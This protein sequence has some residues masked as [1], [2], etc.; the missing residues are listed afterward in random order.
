MYAAGCTVMAYHHVGLNPVPPALFYPK[1]LDSLRLDAELL[2][3]HCEELMVL[4]SA[5]S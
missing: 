1:S 4:G 3:K 2:P 5:F